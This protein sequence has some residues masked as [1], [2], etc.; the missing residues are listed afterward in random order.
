MY[1]HPNLFYV[2]RVSTHLAEID[3][4]EMCSPSTHAVIE[5]IASDAFVEGA[6]EDLR[7]IVERYGT[8]LSVPLTEDI[9]CLLAC[10]DVQLAA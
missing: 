8:F 3:P 5:E 1:A 7:V 2:A 9:K 4:H 10:D 6:D